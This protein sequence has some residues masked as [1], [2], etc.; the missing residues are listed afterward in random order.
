LQQHSEIGNELYQT[1]EHS[2]ESTSSPPTFRQTSG[3]PVLQRPRRTRKPPSWMQ[4]G[5]YILD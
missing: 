3:A 5:D 2:G 1:S 4:S